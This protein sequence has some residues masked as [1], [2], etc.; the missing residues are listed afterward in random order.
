M[1]TPATA[2]TSQVFQEKMFER[3]REQMGDLLSQDDLK[4]IVNSAVE[5]AFFEPRRVKDG[6]HDTIKPPLFQELIEKQLREQ[7]HASITVWLT[8]HPDEVK[9]AIDN[10]IAQGFLGIV[11]QELHQRIA[12]PLQEFANKLREKGILG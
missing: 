8:E 4:V 5:R 2:L 9:K 3:V 6:F 1:S 11:I 12:W 7:V 10:V